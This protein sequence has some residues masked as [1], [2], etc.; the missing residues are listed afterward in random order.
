M[1]EP[2]VLKGLISIEE[3]ADYMSLSPHTIRLWARQHRISYCRVGRRMLIRPVDLEKLI[4]D[5]LVPA[6][7]V[8]EAHAKDRPRGRAE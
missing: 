3:A 7:E 1:S 2:V 4:L 6:K 8:E 5:G